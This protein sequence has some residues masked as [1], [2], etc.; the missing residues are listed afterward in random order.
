V[1]VIWLMRCGCRAF[2][3]ETTASTAGKWNLKV[4]DVGA[5]YVPRHLLVL[6]QERRASPAL[7]NPMKIASLSKG[8]LLLVHVTGAVTFIHEDVEPTVDERRWT[9]RSR[10]SS[11]VPQVVVLKTM[12]MRKAESQLPIAQ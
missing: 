8:I 9:A 3:T 12:S 7:A 1:L 11:I 5:E 6:A 2:Q 10:T 4:V